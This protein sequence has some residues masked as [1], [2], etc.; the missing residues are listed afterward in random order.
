MGNEDLVLLGVGP[1]IAAMLAWITAGFGLA[2][3]LLLR[4]DLE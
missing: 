1:A 3:V 2:A 4:R